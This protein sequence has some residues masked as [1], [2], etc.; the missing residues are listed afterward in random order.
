M[1][2]GGTPTRERGWGQERQGP[3][4]L[5]SIKK[6]GSKEQLVSCCLPGCV[7]RGWAGFC[8]RMRSY[9]KPAYWP[10]STGMETAQIYPADT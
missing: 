2:G 8:V 1:G 6:G 4:H 7:Y 10:L 9:G 3:L 5:I